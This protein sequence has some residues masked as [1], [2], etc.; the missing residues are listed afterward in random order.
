MTET[1]QPDRP[2]HAHDTLRALSS[3]TRELRQM[4]PG[5]YEGYS[6]LSGAAFAEGALPKKVKELIALAIGVVDMCDGCIASHASGAAKAGAT[7]EEVAEMIGVT[8]AM[9]GG[10]A[11]VHGAR[12]YAAFLE[13]VD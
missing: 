8:F 10:P 4:I 11:T 5:V 7:R 12:A 6:A 13:Y 2:T 1:T 3:Q 9:R